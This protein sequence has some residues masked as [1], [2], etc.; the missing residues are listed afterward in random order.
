MFAEV[1]KQV[2]VDRFL[3]ELRKGVIKSGSGLTEEQCKEQEGT[4][5]VYLIGNNGC[6]LSHIIIKHRKLV[7][8][9]IN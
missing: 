4:I 1:R 9:Y 7:Y 3:A 8:T 2:E 6:T 5:A